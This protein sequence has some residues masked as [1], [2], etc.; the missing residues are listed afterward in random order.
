MKKL[1]LVTL[2]ILQLALAT[3][4]NAQNVGINAT[5]SLPDNS[6]MLDVSST[7]KGFLAPRLTTTQ[8][9][10]ISLPATGL[11]IFN[12]TDNVFKV[13]TGTPA[14]PL[15]TPLAMGSGLSGTGYPK[16]TGSV[17]TYITA[18]PNT[19]LANSAITIQGT[20]TSLGGTVNIINGTG[21][22]KAAGTTIS[23][24]NNTYLTSATAR[25]NI[26]LTTTG[27]SG[28]ATYN[29]STGVLNVPVYPSSFSIA[30]ASDAT[31]T[32]PSNGQILQY[33]FATGKWVN[34]TPSFLS[35]YI[36]T[37]PIV[38]A[39]NGMVK[40][41]GT[42]ISAAIAGTDYTTP[43][44]TETVTN[45]NLTSGTNTFPI[46]NQ[47][48]TGNAATVT[49]NAN[50]TGPITSV[51]NATSITN[52]AVTYSKMQAMTANKLLG[53]GLAGTAVSEITLGTGLSFTGN[54][55]NAATTGGT[56]TSASVVAANGFTGSV[57]TATTTPA[58]TL[59]T[60]ITGILKG[61]GTAISAAI[62]SD[63]P[64]LNQNTT[65]TSANVTGTVAVTNG[66]TGLTSVTTGDILYGSAA[67]TL[68]KL[69][70]GTNGQVLT[71][72]SGIPSWATPA[73]SSSWSLTG[74]AATAG[75]HFLGSTNN[76]S[77]RFRTNNTERMIIDS[78]GKVGVGLSDP[79]AGYYLSVKD[80]LE[81]RRTAT[82]AQMIFTNTAGSGNFRI[83]G[84]GGD[85]YWQGGGGQSLQMG[86]YWATVLGGDRQ[87]AAFPAFIGG[88]SGTSVIVASQRDASVAL[89]I[90]G[91]SA[92]QTAN[93]TEWKNS[94]GT[95][96]AVVDK[97]GNVGIGVPTPTAALH[98]EAGTAS[99]N[100]APL[101]FT[102]GTNL[103]T[104]E[105]G[106]VEFNGTHFY[107][108]VG[109]TRYQLDQ[110]A[111]GGTTT[112]ANGG[113]GQ[114]AALTAGG[115]VYG[116][117][118]TAMGVTSAGTSGQV[119]QSTGSGTPAWVNG[120]TMMLSG[121]TNN[122]TETTTSGG[123]KNYYPVT[124]TISSVSTSDVSAGTRTVMSRAGTIRNLYVVLDG[125]PGGGKN[126]TVTIYKGGTAQTLTVAINGN[127][128]V[129]GSD[130]TN[131]FTVAAGDEV[132]IVISSSST[133]STHR[134]V[135]W[136][137]EFTY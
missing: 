83:G 82:T 109:S 77:L 137:A 17:P 7:D 132:G 103:T 24:D 26:S 65:G 15:W 90:Q 107:G 102:A 6:A 10:A 72:T 105:N 62:A 113:T 54:T 11:L 69:P 44:S 100:T 129:N 53:S 116:A 114:T 43:S 117:S 59:G 128:T 95:V 98:L 16:F 57:A 21:F 14:V 42:T 2:L 31:I 66:G 126:I 110:Q 37:D 99:A 58:I 124:G 84:D 85:I 74:N 119:L 89:G 49:T 9:N 20:A 78:T 71:L 25:T 111:A 136:S 45:K 40:S 118:T 112:V 29:N 28:A 131:S 3:K 108:T 48:T 50:L 64:T 91:N 38:K 52:N 70:A 1:Y 63:F 23:Y 32:T 121:N 73:A 92:S 120:G 56:V 8:Q 97:S 55:L 86:S 33:N 123:Q 133:P 96:L 51:G 13:N 125:A 101:K 60:T 79:A 41:N 134:R 106:A 46:F 80:N 130:T 104:P 47:N 61:N 30:G 93:L 76:V 94:A 35:S 4:T 12:T 68:S 67:N 75:T 34:T 22:V 135:S 88:I 36:E 18:I 27:T 115:V 39:I 5:S 81:I 122:S 127:V 87:T 19:D